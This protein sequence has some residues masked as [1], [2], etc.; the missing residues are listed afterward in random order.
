MA[1]L[2][3]GRICIEKR[4]R[5]AGQKVIVLGLE[6]GKAVVAGKRVKKHAVNVLHVFPTE[7][8]AKISAGASQT[9]INQAL[10]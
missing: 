10:E 5:N 1:I 3:T 7:K 8:V 9:E 6:K 2:E 4:G